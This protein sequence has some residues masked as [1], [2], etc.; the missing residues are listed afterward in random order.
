MARLFSLAEANALIPQLSQ[1]FEALAETRARAGL[2]RE[3]LTQI[4]TRGHSNGKD[5]STEIR[6]RQNELE[7][8]QA[9]PQTICDRIVEL[10]CEVKDLEPG[11]VDFPSDRDGRTVY[12]CWK[13]GEDSIRFWHE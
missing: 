6:E 13:V 2:V 9:E 3:G 10:G 1:E 7:A 11:L 5:L 8:L 12:L 4:E